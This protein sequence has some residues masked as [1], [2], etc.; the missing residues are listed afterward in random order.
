MTNLVSVERARVRY[1]EKVVLDG[2]SLGIDDGD[3]VGVIGRNGGGKSTL[4]RVLAG[5]QAP[6]DGAVVHAGRLAVQLVRQDPDLA[7]DQTALDVVVDAD[8]GP[9]RIFARFTADPSDPRSTALMDAHG[10][11]D[12]EHVAR[13]LLDRF[14]VAPEQLI[15]QLSGGQRMRVALARGLVHSDVAA[16]TGDTVPLLILDE[17]TNHLDLDAIEWLEQRIRSQRGAVVLVTHDRYLLDRTATRIVEVA[18][19]TLYTEHGSYADY[20]ANRAERAQQAVTREH[21]RQQRARTELSWLQRSPPARTSKSRS[22]IERAMTLLDTEPPVAD[23]DVHIDLPARR[24]G[25]KVA[26]LHNVGRRYG[27][28]VVLRDVEANLQPGARI[29]IVGP[30]GS[31]KTTLLELIAGRQEP[32]DGSVRL[33]STVHVGWYGQHTTAPP[34]RQRV[35]DAVSEVVV[36]T[37]DAVGGRTVAVT[38]VLEQFGFA[39]ATQQA[40]VSE[41]S[42]GERRRLELLR[43]LATAPNLLL[44]DEPTNDLDIDTL[45]V[46]EGF[47][48]HWP[49]TLVTASHDRF[50]LDRVCHQL[51]TIEPGGTIRDHP[52]GWTAYQA[53]RTAAPSATAAA[54][55]A[56]QRPSAAS[57]EPRAAARRGKLSYNEQRELRAL[58]RAVPALEARRDGL[59][60]ALIDAADDHVRAGD[61]ALALDDVV[62]QID[63]DETRWL[64]LQMRTDPTTQEQQ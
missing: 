20:L 2:V 62:A 41:L 29:G 52:G 19:G 55:R 28:T 61:L 12:F 3:R 32:D 9:G 60:A 51:W 30:N 46:L 42:G 23:A 10:L 24:L 26:T 58:E 11:W 5:T 48:E 59:H 1:A 56:S 18:G 31:G 25:S 17:P 54:G 50:F 35:V 8:S 4:L 63:H 33:G 15:G 39:T 49:G 36:D 40:F 43:V 13:A 44:L 27:D 45:A 6:D 7:A 47:L 53:Q 16:R 57:R 38:R 22:R 34:A 21:R 14:D 37:H 64:E